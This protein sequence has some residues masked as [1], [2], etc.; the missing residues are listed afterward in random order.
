MLQRYHDTAAVYFFDRTVVVGAWLERILDEAYRILDE[1]FP[2][3][4][5]TPV[6]GGNRKKLYFQLIANIQYFRDRTDAMPCDLGHRKKCDQAV[7]QCDFCTEISDRR[8]FYSVI[9][10]GLILTELR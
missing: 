5:N 4:R 8:Y 9:L 1:L 2:A 10:S 6:V 3:H 7:W